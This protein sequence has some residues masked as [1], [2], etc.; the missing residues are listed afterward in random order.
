MISIRTFHVRI[1]ITGDFWVHRG[2]E[3]L[4]HSSAEPSIN[5]QMATKRVIYIFMYNSRRQVESN[6]YN[7]NIPQRLHPPLFI[8]PLLEV[9]SLYETEML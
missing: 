5:N 6:I 4:F 3:F 1:I 9:H 7:M 8:I 2:W